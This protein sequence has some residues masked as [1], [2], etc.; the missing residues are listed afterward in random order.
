MIVMRYLLIVV[1]FLN[2]ISF[3]Q[4]KD[5]NANNIALYAY[6]SNNIEG[7]PSS[8]SR[9]LKNKLNQIVTQNGIGGP[10]INPR[11]I[12][13]PNITILSKDITSS[14]PP[15]IAYNLEV[16]FYIGDG[17]DGTKYAS[18]SLSVKGVG[19]NETKAYIQAIKQ[20]K[21]KHPDLVSFIEEGK[22]KII[23]YYNTNCDLIL[24][25]AR[26]TSP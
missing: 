23:D 12:I 25:E 2:V 18:T 16:T 9:M 7:M 13:T 19:T 14:A 26:G 4:E 11:F 3:G 8:A 17:V 10:V 20:I 6:V 21:T 15:M 1:L 24:K 5:D 22:Q